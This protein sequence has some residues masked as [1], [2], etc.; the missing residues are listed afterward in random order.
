[1]MER[2]KEAMEKLQSCPRCEMLHTWEE[3]ECERCGWEFGFSHHSNDSDGSTKPD[4]GSM[5]LEK[6]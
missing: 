6:G 2:V 5:T 1:M 4:T 3:Y